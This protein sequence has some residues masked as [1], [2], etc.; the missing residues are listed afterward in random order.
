MG[1]RCDMCK[2]CENIVTEMKIDESPCLCIKDNKIQV[3]FHGLYEEFYEVN[4]CPICGR[5][6]VKE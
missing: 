5:K 4:Y 2:F 1:L 6:L 3:Y